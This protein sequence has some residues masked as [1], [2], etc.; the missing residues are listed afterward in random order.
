MG[1]LLL[2]LMFAVNGK[3]RLVPHP[4]ALPLLL[5]SAVLFVGGTI[6]TLSDTT[7]S[8]DTG[9]RLLAPE[10]AADSETGIE[11]TTTSS[12]MAVTF[13]TLLLTTIAQGFYPSSVLQA[14]AS[15][16]CSQAFVFLAAAIAALVST[17][18]S[19]SGIGQQ[20][21]NG[22]YT[23][24]ADAVGGKNGN[25]DAQTRKMDVVVVDDGRDVESG[26][27]AAREP[28]NSD[29]K[30]DQS[31]ASLTSHLSHTT[32]KL[33]NGSGKEEWIKRACWILFLLPLAAWIGAT[34][35]AALAPVDGMVL[36]GEVGVKG[37][38]WL[39]EADYDV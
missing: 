35:R 18:S 29:T 39:R 31:D 33:S 21:R 1:S 23:D 28:T 13:F 12:A 24:L 26:V 16:L 36:G 2:V 6:S 20:S 8:N 4:M 27:V 14:P 30:L 37:Y 5:F 10:Q 7:S 34:T 19:I 22:S 9:R 15:V 32:T 17:T 38:G 25:V 11:W 3:E